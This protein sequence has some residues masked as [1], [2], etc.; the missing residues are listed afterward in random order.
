MKSLLLSL[1]PRAT[2]PFLE[3]SPSVTLNIRLRV[4][5][6]L[7]I[8]GPQNAFKKVSCSE[9]AVE[10]IMEGTKRMTRREEGEEGEGGKGFNSAAS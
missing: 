10:S 2:C 8:D 5:I 7:L 9:S 4:R 3:S 1:L 6:F